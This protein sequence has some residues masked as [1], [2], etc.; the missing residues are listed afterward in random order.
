MTATPPNSTPAGKRVS[1]R[2]P[3]DLR[4]LLPSVVPSQGPRPLCLPFAV[5]AAHCGARSVATATG[6]TSLAVE[7][8]WCACVHSGNAGPD[9]TTVEAAGGALELIGQPEEAVW[10]YNELLGHG[11]EG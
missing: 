11:T 10:P 5:A 7:A 6:P 8:L 4:A 9:G 3:V 2:P 1:G